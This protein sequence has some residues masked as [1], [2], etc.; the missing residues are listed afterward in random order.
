MRPFAGAAVTDPNGLYYMRARYYHPRLKRFLN[1]DILPG[2]VIEGQTF[3]RFAYVNGD[4][5]GFIDPLGLAG[6]GTDDCPKGN[7]GTTKGQT[8]ADIMNT[9]QEKL[10]PALKKIRELDPNAKVGYRGSLATG[11]K[12]PHKGNAPFDPTDFEI[13]AFI[14][15]DKLA[16][17]FPTKTKWRSGADIRRS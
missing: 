5:V 10:S 17:R 9:V 16:S 15:S 11:Q 13:D 14:V 12:D 8:R 1:R 7:K 3:N 6:L 2:D 4:P